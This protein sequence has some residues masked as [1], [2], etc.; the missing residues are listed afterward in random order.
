MEP[1]TYHVAPG[2]Y[3]MFATLALALFV[4]WGSMVWNAGAPWEP[5]AL[6][7]IA[8]AGF[9]LW[10]SRYRVVF[11]AREILVVTPRAGVRHLSCRDILSVELAEP[12]GRKDADVLTI[13]TSSGEE[14]HLDTRFFPGEVVQRLLALGPRALVQG[15][16]PRG[17]PAAARASRRRP[18]ARRGPE[19]AE[20]GYGA[21]DFFRAS[22]PSGTCS[23]PGL[24]GPA[25][26]GFPGRA[27]A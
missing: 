5:L 25:A 11:G 3:G 2:V 13:R 24:P 21:F 18:V 14:L 12:P 26:S 27:R 22:N 15:F 7:P 19:G 20:P 17:R 16:S 23:S 9:V 6:P 4:L 1:R 10:M 8:F